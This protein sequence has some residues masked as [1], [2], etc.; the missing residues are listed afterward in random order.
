MIKLLSARLSFQNL[1]HPAVFEGKEGK[2]EAVFLLP[3]Q[4]P[5]DPKQENP[6]V[7]ALRAA[8]TELIKNY[9]CLLY[10]SPSPRD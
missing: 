4:D 2:H 6:Q 9:P 1:F 7:V 10:T 5:D 3:R 8:A